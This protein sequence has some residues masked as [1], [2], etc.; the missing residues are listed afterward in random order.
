MVQRL[1]VQEL[2]LT[3]TTKNE[4]ET[5]RVEIFTA[6]QQCD[7]TPVGSNA[8]K[9]G[10]LPHICLPSVRQVT[11]MVFHVSTSRPQSRSFKAWPPTREAEKPWARPKSNYCHS[12]DEILGAHDEAHI[13]PVLLPLILG[14]PSPPAHLAACV[15]THPPPPG[16]AVSSPYLASAPPVFS[17]S[18]P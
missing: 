9:S 18:P 2:F 1:W 11:S 16:Q 10:L 14:W 6:F 12:P 13:S 5:R 17:A 4:I 15:R 3:S 7:F 8:A